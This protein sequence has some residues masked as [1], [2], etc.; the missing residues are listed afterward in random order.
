MD[1]DFA[2]GIDYINDQS[3]LPSFRYRDKKI[4]KFIGQLECPSSHVLD[5]GEYNKLTERLGSIIP[6]FNID[7]THGDLD[8]K[9]IHP[10]LHLKDYDLVIFSHVI[11]HLFNP[12]LCLERIKMVMKPDAILVIATPIKPHYLP[13]GKGHFHEMDKYRFRK[14]M[15]RAGLDIITWHRFRNRPIFGGAR[16]M[17]RRIFF[18]EQ[19]LIITKIK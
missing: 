8:A 16:Q 10:F 7:N 5:I 14:L 12:L 13:W 19:S 11:E 17:I 2:R 9:I 4:I 15:D 6:Y 18:K 1:K 3:E